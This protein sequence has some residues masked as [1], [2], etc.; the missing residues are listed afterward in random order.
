MVLQG[1]VKIHP[2][3]T[4]RNRELATADRLT[5]DIEPSCSTP[6]KFG[7]PSIMKNCVTEPHYR[8]IECWQRFEQQMPLRRRVTQI[9]IK[10][11]HHDRAR[12]QTQVTHGIKKITKMNRFK[13]TTKI[14]TNSNKK[15]KF[16]YFVQN[17]KCTL[18][19]K[20]L[21]E[22]SDEILDNVFYRFMLH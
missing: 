2:Y 13:Q 9:I 20:F 7:R 19:D 6:I 1:N 3:M 18:L 16:A 11:P 8:K 5:N 14:L 22:F 21:G 15:E 12:G 10:I 4:A 17:F